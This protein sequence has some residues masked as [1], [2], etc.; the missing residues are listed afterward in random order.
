MFDS[1]QDL[2][3]NVSKCLKV[4]DEKDHVNQKLDH[5]EGLFKHFKT[6]ARLISEEFNIKMFGFDVIGDI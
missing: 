2:F 6:L 3:G 4:V 5:E 1:Q